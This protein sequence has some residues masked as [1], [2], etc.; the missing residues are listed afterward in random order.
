M[1]ITLKNKEV[2]VKEIRSLSK[3][4]KNDVLKVTAAED[5]LI[6]EAGNGEIFASKTVLDSIVEKEELVTI[7]EI[8][9]PGQMLLDFSVLS[10]LTNL[11][12]DEV[13][14]S[15]ADNTLGIRTK[16]VNLKLN[17]K[18][19]AVFT[20]KP[21]CE[22]TPYLPVVKKSFYS[23]LLMNV[24]YACE[25]KDKAPRP[26]LKGIQIVS[27]G[28]RVIATGTDSRRA[29]LFNYEL[30]TEEIPSIIV[31]NKILAD[32]LLLFSDEEVVS[33]IGNGFLVLKQES[34]TV[35]M[36]LIDGAY[37]NVAP[38]FTI[39]DT[40]FR[41]QVDLKSLKSVI[42]LTDSFSSFSK[43][44]DDIKKV[45]RFSAADT[46]LQ[47]QCIHQGGEFSTELPVTVT[48]GTLPE[49]FNVNAQFLKEAIATGNETIILSF[50]GPKLYVSTIAS[51][52]QVVMGTKAN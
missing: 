18:C 41:V 44:K 28:E 11:V 4:A 20:E 51:L 26:V 45:I 3:Y 13:V 42:K 24:G 15:V 40:A 23:E 9:Q 32:A 7:F 22:L 52:Q 39:S 34:V 50:D 10:V 8:E 36:K 17:L 37:P 12:E 19:D 6:L 2:I 5:H 30:K 38:L 21:K 35:F 25:T 47:V 29:A 14:L 43:E 33:E 1:K 46:G 49:T 48:A 16:S 27:N 31:P